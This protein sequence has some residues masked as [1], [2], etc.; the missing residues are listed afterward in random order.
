MDDIIIK[1]WD[2]VPVGSV[3]TALDTKTGIAEFTAPEKGD[4]G[5]MIITFDL[6]TDEITSL[7][8]SY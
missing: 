5:P 7:I 8:T 2:S 1:W 6:F 3:L 4:F